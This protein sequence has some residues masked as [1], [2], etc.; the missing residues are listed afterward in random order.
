MQTVTPPPTDEASETVARGSR[1]E[2]TRAATTEEIKQ[3]AL[4][5]M[6][7]QRSTDIR[8]TD[9]AKQMGM[10]PPALYRYFAGRDELLPALITDSYDELSA[11]GRDSLNGTDPTA[12]WPRWVAAGQAYRN[13]A[14]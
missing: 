1:R 8:F 7:E 10:T 5:L 2:R 6:R 11:H 13:W 12:P 9:I 4:A 3:T 14:H